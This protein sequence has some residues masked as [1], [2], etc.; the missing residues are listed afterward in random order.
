[1]LK[2]WFEQG[3]LQA[4]VMQPTYGLGEVHQAFTRLLSSGVYGKIA[5]VPTKTNAA[6]VV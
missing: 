6:V 2:T 1:M 4:R 3:K 5:V